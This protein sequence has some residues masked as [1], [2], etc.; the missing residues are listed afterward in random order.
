MNKNEKPRPEIGK[1]FIELVT[2]GMYEDCRDIYREYIQNSADA[3]AACNATAI[4][5]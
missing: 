2:E 3:I 4:P 1:S 5:D